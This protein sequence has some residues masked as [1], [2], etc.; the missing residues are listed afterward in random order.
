M[1]DKCRSLYSVNNLV[2][3]DNLL[4]VNPLMGAGL[5]EKMMRAYTE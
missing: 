5:I 4:Y 1:F 3:N 2:N